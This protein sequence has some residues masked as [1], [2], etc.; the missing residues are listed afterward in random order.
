MEESRYYKANT[1]KE[2]ISLSRTI[3]N[4]T[5]CKRKHISHIIHRRSFLLQK[6]CPL[7]F[8]LIYFAGRANMR[9]RCCNFSNQYQHCKSIIYKLTNIFA[10]AVEIR[11]QYLSLYTNTALHLKEGR[12]YIYIYIEVQPIL[13]PLSSSRTLY[14]TSS[15]ILIQKPITCHI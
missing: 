6:A 4:D 12:W 1:H 14:P 9:V 11:K 5:L 3:S 10:Y 2:R 8:P 13:R 7:L 15:R